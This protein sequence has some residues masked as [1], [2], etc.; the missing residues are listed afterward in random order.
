RL[1]GSSN[2]VLEPWR[3]RTVFD[4]LVEVDVTRFELVTDAGA[5]Q[6]SARWRIRDAGDRRILRDGT[7]D[8]SRPVSEPTTSA[9]AGAMSE[10]ASDLARQLAQ[11][12][13]ELPA[14]GPRAQPRDARVSRAA[15]AGDV[16]A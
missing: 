7:A 8:L 1:L 12:I 15:R 4:Y 11:A 9:A 16:D 13:A 2:V 6:L 14:R 5:A 10:A 3:W